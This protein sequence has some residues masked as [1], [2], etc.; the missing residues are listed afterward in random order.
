MATLS[1]YAD[2][3]Q[4][5]LSKLKF[6]SAT[7]IEQE[8]IEENAKIQATS[9]DEQAR[10]Q[11]SLEEAIKSINQ[12][13][14][15]FGTLDHFCALLPVMAKDISAQEME[16]PPLSFFLK[17]LLAAS[18]NSM[19]SLFTL[20]YRLHLRLAS[21]EHNSSAKSR[22][23]DSRL[24]DYIR[25]LQ[26]ASWFVP[27][28]TVFVSPSNKKVYDHLEPLFKSVESDQ[29]YTSLDSRLQKIAQFWRTQGERDLI[30]QGREVPE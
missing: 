20:Y 17:N 21:L 4:L 18:V 8:M 10:K 2:Y 27:V 9:L 24:V 3:L 23:Y 11:A 15:I 22:Y 1:Q 14:S 19:I 25:V 28:C 6:Y 30:N 29:L 7:N 16:D 5:F 12:G 13:N 26:V